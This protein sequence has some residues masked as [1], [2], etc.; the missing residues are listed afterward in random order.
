M[1]EPPRKTGIILADDHAVVRSALRALLEGEPDFR[2][3]AEAADARAARE[4]AEAHAADVLLVDL[5][6]PGDSVLDTIAELSSRTSKPAIVVLTMESEP[7]LMR[8]A[9]DAGASGYV[10]KQAADRELVAAVRAA[11]R[12]ERYVQPRGREAAVR[13]PVAEDGLTDRETEVLT[14]IARGHTSGDIAEMLGISVRTVESHRGHIQ[15]KLRLEG[16]P[17]LV[18]YALDRGLLTTED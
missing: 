12:G 6:M 9:L 18:R 10:L 13:R 8:A 7:A 1:A 17:E 15:Q 2:V 3:L 4:Q 16:R 11:A 5:N 14:L